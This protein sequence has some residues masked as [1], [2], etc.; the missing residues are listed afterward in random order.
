M[1]E[2]LR[3]ALNHAL[4]DELESALSRIVH[5]VNQLN[6]SQV[7]WR[8]PEGTN[9]IG[10]LILHLTGNVKQMVVTNLTGAADTRDRPAEFAARE[11]VPKDELV[12][13]LAA[14]VAQAREAV[15]SASDARLV[16]V[17]KV[18]NNDWTGIQAAVRSI[19]HFRGHAQEIIHITRTV[20]GAAYQFAGPR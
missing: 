15:T 7:W 19:S 14:V 4:C 1:A 10:N 8:P 2:D 11:A 20:L 6:E 17:R 12:A 9:A 13:G 5:C 16:Q 18:N 3:S